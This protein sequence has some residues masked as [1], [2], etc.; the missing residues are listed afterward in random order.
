MEQRGLNAPSPP[1]Q[2]EGG[3]FVSKKLVAAGLVAT[4][5]VVVVVLAATGTIFSG[6]D[7]SS[8]SSADQSG[9]ALAAAD[10][11]A[12]RRQC[13]RQDYI[14]DEGLASLEE[15]SYDL[16]KCCEVK[17]CTYAAVSLLECADGSS[18]YTSTCCGNTMPR[19]LESCGGDFKQWW[20]ESPATVATLAADGRA[21]VCKDPTVLASTLRECGAGA[22]SANKNLDVIFQQ[23]TPAPTAAPTPVPTAAP[24]PVPTAAP[25][26]APTA[27]P[28][29]A[30]TAVMIPEEETCLQDRGLEPLPGVK[31]GS[32]LQVM[33][34]PEGV[35]VGAPYTVTIRW[36]LQRPRAHH[37]NFDLDD[38]LGTKQYFGG[39][40]ITVDP[41]G[42]GYTLEE[43]P[44]NWV[45]CGEHSFQMEEFTG[46]LTSAG[47]GVFDIMWKFFSSPIWGSEEEGQE[48]DNDSFPNMLAETGIPKQPTYN[49]GV[50]NDCV[51]VPTRYWNLPPTGEQDAIDFPVIPVDCVVEGQP[52][53]IKIRTHI[54][55][56]KAGDLHVNLMVGTGGD[57]YLGPDDIYIGESNVYGIQAE[58]VANY[59][60][61]GYWTDH[62]IVFDAQTTDVMTNPLVQEWADK[63]P[64][65]VVQIYVTG[66]LVPEG[67]SFYEL[68]PDTG[69]FVLDEEGNMV[70]KAVLNDDG[71]PR[72]DPSFRDAN[73]DPIPMYGWDIRERENFFN[74][75][76]P[77]TDP[78]FGGNCIPVDV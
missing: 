58:D 25:T 18:M 30:P 57:V 29:M 31:P 2:E 6:S 19:S 72:L 65:K 33:C 46:Q 51:P 26:P 48:P 12:L 40:G 50:V 1:V 63:N 38:R 59:W 43:F 10:A 5:A 78:K 34:I 68:D 42:E 24:T 45:Q 76:L 39:R 22:K 13:A 11:A 4:A 7:S 21:V 73:G 17:Q 64:G 35:D 55:S 36:C 61:E 37:V 44:L 14:L 47:T 52:L 27:A 28:T 67:D 3:R 54:E 71:T 74:I 53:A 77:G 16:D 20:Q 49:Q 66:F 15:F 32:C 23:P 9:S 8:G 56:M 70:V 69:D 62:E 60:E 41:V 75:A